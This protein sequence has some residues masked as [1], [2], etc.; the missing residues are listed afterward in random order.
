MLWC[1]KVLNQKIKAG[2]YVILWLD[3]RRK[4]LIHLS[5]QEEF[6]TH[7]GIIKT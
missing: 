3:N 7:K 5:K 1:E 6:H 2:M 4:W